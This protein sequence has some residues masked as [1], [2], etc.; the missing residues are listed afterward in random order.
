MDV[1]EAEY[2]ALWLVEH[3]ALGVLARF[4]FDSEE[5]MQPRW[6]ALALALAATTRYRKD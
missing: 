4:P 6:D 1:P 3:I 2:N 5:Q